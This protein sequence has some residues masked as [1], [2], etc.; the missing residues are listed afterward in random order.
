MGIVAEKKALRDARWPCRRRIEASWVAVVVASLTVA[1]MLAPKSADA[2]S[3]TSGVGLV[4]KTELTRRVRGH[5]ATASARCKFVQRSLWRARGEQHVGARDQTARGDHTKLLLWETPACHARSSWR[6]LLT[7]PNLHHSLARLQVSMVL[8]HPGKVAS[9][10]KK[11]QVV[12]VSGP[13]GVGKGSIIQL[14]QQTLGPARV[15]LCVSHTTRPPRA[16]EVE[17]EHYYFT[18]KQEMEHEIS[19]G[20]F[21]ELADVHGI[22]ILMHGCNTTNVRQAVDVWELFLKLKAA[23]KAPKADPSMEKRYRQVFQAPAVKGI[24]KID[25]AVCNTLVR[26]M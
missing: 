9:V 19:Q 2:F 25:T 20:G 18:S 4:L 26:F 15:A 8:D 7:P 21:L 23:G 3:L 12:V 13:S 14:V 17:G 24:L 22:D 6:Q 11:A 5:R 1:A 16:G 10:A